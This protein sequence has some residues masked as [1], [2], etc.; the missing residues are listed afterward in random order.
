MHV[1]NVRQYFLDTM[2]ELVGIKSGLAVTAPK[3]VELLDRTSSPCG[4]WWHGDNDEGV[5]LARMVEET[6]GKKFRRLDAYRYNSASIRV[7]I[8]DPVFKGK[9]AEAR[10]AIVEPIL[11]KLP[12]RT[13]AGIMNLFIFA[14]EEI[15]NP[16]ISM[17]H[18]FM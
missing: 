4:R 18:F 5:R 3:A 7:R 11:D 14:P 12:E 9:K 15:K 8:I 1:I 10:D 2:V 13:Q 6:L 16:D 17:R